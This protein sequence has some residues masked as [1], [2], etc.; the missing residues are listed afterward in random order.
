[1]L[2]SGESTLLKKHSCAQRLEK[3]ILTLVGPI[4]ALAAGDVV[5]RFGKKTCMLVEKLKRQGNHKKTDELAPVV[6][7]RNGA[8]RRPSGSEVRV[9]VVWSES[10]KEGAQ[11]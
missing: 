11:V 2:S 6:A 1:M 5:T 7:V 10:M 3:G 4:K 9:Q 8:S